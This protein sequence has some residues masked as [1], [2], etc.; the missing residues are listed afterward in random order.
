MKIEQ[1]KIVKPKGQKS[2]LK[3]FF[4]PTISKLFNS[5]YIFLIMGFFLIYACLDFFLSMF[6]DFFM[7]LSW[8]GIVKWEYIAMGV[9]ILSAHVFASYLIACFLANVWKT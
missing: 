5:I 4:R 9:I 1:R 6:R 8:G 2:P 7:F 3:E